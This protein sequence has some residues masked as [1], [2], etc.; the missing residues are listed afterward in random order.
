MKKFPKADRWEGTGGQVGRRACS[1]RGGRS[2]NDSEAATDVK[3]EVPML[4]LGGLEG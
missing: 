2:V 1:Q 3:S 4:I